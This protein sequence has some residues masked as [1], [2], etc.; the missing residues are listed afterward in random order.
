METPEQWSGRVEDAAKPKFYECG[1]CG[2]CHPAEWNGDCREDANRFTNQQLDDKYGQD[3]WQE[4]P[5][6]D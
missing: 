1:I 3:G 4:V 2:H 6:P 5:M